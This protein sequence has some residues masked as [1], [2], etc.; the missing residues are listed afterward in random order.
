MTVLAASEVLMGL[1]PLHGGNLDTQLQQTM[2]T[3]HVW[4]RYANIS[5]MKNASIRYMGG[6]QNNTNI[7][8]YKTYHSKL[9][10]LTEVNGKVVLY[11]KLMEGLS[12]K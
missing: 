8:I 6:S 1:S 2:D 9:D 11:P 3:Q 10:F 12:C 5:Y 4:Y 7:Y